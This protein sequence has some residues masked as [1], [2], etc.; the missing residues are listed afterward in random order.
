VEF[1]LPAHGPDVHPSNTAPARGVAV[2]VTA[3]PVG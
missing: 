2:S 3:V 1:V